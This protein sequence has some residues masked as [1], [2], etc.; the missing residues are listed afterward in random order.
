MRRGAVGVLLLLPLLF[1][2]AGYVPIM[3]PDWRDS[4]VVLTPADPGYAQVSLDQA[5]KPAG[6]GGVSEAQVVRL[7]RDLPVYRMWS[8]PDK[9]NASGQTN[10]LG[11]WWSF[12]RPT[13][14][15]SAYRSDYEICLSWNDLTWVA[16][17]TL[18]AGAV[19][20]IGPGQSVDA[21]TCANPAGPEMY[22]PNKKGWQV[23]VDRPWAQPAA[24]F[25]CP[26]VS[27]DYQADPWEIGRPR[28][29]A[30]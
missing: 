26:P 8:G 23:Y 19:V 2:V 12:D 17:C 27:A 28:A 30:Q 10:R 16:A 24:V 22:G 7:T 4:I 9:L 1:L 20:A 13:G 29:S 11:S 25:E 6:Q 5:V 3:G 21:A 15:V 14:S 18:K